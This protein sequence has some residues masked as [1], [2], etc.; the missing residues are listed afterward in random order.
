MALDGSK[1]F[2]R[3]NL[4]VLDNI[5][6]YLD[7]QS[8]ESLSTVNK[9]FQKR[10]LDQIS[11]VTVTWRHVKVSQSYDPPLF[12]AR[13]GIIIGDKLY[14]PFMTM[15]PVCYMMDIRT[16]KWT[17]HPLALQNQDHFEAVVTCAAAIGE[18]IYFFGGRQ[19]QSYRLS[20]SLYKL[21]VK[22]WVLEKLRPNGPAPRPR[23]EHTVNAIFDRY[24]VVF[25]GMCYHSVGENDVFVYDSVENRWIEPT[26]NG[27]TP[28][29]RFGHAAC[30]AGKDLYVYGGSRIENDINV[31]YEDLHKLDCET[32]TWIKY[33]DPETTWQRDRAIRQSS[34]EP[35]DIIPRSP[36]HPTV[37][38]ANQ[39]RYTLP[40]TGISPRERYRPG[41][42]L[43]ENKLVIFGGHTIAHDEDDMSEIYDYALDDMCILSLDRLHW[44]H[45]YGVTLDS[46]NAHP[47][48]ENFRPEPSGKIFAKEM[49]YQVLPTEALPEERRHGYTLFIIGLRKL[50]ESGST[51]LVSA[52]TK[53]AKAVEDDLLD[54][55]GDDVLDLG[56]TNSL[57]KHDYRGSR[58]P[59]R[60]RIPEGLRVKEIQRIGE[61]PPVVLDNYEKGQAFPT[62]PGCAISVSSDTS[63]SSN[64]TPPEV[65]RRPR[66]YIKQAD[67]EIDYSTSNRNDNIN[68]LAADKPPDA[69]SDPDTGVSPPDYGPQQ[70][71]ITAKARSFFDMEVD[72][73]LSQPKEIRTPPRYMSS[74]GTFPTQASQRKSRESLAG[75]K[76][77]WL[78][79]QQLDGDNENPASK[80]QR[81]DASSSSEH[82]FHEDSRRFA[83][84]PFC[85]LLTLNGADEY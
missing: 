47:G 11:F 84:A 65:Q 73:N 64:P 32:W 15:E 70:D 79:N 62:N 42:V 23:H 3:L 58:K 4:D 6:S 48:V 18:N 26:I 20:N 83:L 81:A 1:L 46:E 56:M 57:E 10:C 9:F 43:V 7:N 24:L 25:G 59:S 54:L 60:K 13:S 50:F 19:I 63:E 49:I 75:F 77:Q 61:A 85:M 38:I 68:P 34:R 74:D 16:W 45:A 17:V 40:T 22:T 52:V 27:Y 39:T 55:R 30:V 31:V 71:F 28:H 5:F 33:E 69:V 80:S 53:S 78:E 66:V 72:L 41:M 21:N 44:T 37:Q 82:W 51:R 36:A 29:V 76:V 12:N 67:E 14:V 2:E 8:L 35:M